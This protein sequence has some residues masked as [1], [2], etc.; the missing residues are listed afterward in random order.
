MEL[1]R[2]HHEV[3]QRDVEVPESR[4]ARE[5]VMRLARDVEDQLCTGVARTVLRRDDDFAGMLRL[6]IVCADCIIRQ[7][8]DFAAVLCRADRRVQCG[9]RRTGAASAVRIAAVR[10]VQINGFR[11]R[12]R[13][14]PCSKKQQKSGKADRKAAFCPF[15]HA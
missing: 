3:F 8:N 15:V 14:R 5:A 1:R 7:Q 4:R 6:G 13:D 9:K 10:R 2:E 11:R 12:G